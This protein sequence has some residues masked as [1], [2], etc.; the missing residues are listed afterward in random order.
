MEKKTPERTLLF[1]YDLDNHLSRVADG[2]NATVASYGY[3]FL[4][5]RI[6]KDVRGVKTFYH[7]SDSGLVAEMDAS[8]NVRKSYGYRPDSPWGTDPLFVRENG[9]NYWFLNDHLGTPQQIVAENGGVVW[10]AQ[11]QVFGKAEIDGSSTLTNNLRFPGQYY[12]EE[13]CLH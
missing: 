7:Y 8:G 11:Y 4:R 3:D 12:D 6:W 13:T 9:K 1:E 5:R 10:K 2:N